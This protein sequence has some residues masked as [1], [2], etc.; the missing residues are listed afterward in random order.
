MTKHLVQQVYLHIRVARSAQRARD[1]AD[2]LLPIG[3]LFAGQAFFEQRDG[4]P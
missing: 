1:A 2:L 3:Q 4:A